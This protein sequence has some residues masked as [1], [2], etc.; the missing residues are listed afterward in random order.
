MKRRASFLTILASATALCTAASAAELR[1]TWWGGNSRHA[2]TQAALQAC[3]EKYDHTV[4]AE[5]TGWKGYLE[6][7]TTQLAGGTEADILQVNWPWLPLFSPKGDGFADLTLFSD[8]IDL[9]Q[10]S[11]AE[12]S[13]TTIDGK[14]NGLPLATTGRVF[15][16]N[17]AVFK[18]ADLQLPKN[19]N[20]LVAAAEAFQDKLG[21]DHYPLEVT[22]DNP[23]LIVM[24]VATQKTGKSLVDA[25]TN[26]VAWSIEELS[27]AIDFYGMLVEKKVTRPWKDWASE[28]YIKLYN[29]PN[30]EAGKIAGSYEWDST[31]F[32]YADPLKDDDALVPVPI[33]KIDGAVTEGVFRKPSM[34]FSISKRSDNQ[35]AAAEIVNC[36]LN[37]KEGIEALGATRGLPA[38]RI[39]LA[40][41]KEAGKIAPELVAANDLVMTGT[42]PEV[43]PLSEHPRIRDAFKDALEMY[44]YGEFSSE[45]AADEI[46]YSINEI[47]EK[48]DP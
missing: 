45:Q 25:K 47:L 39:A 28:G 36:L 2:A 10:W 22:E 33:L 34:V 30:W 21:H 17:Q 37:E 4:K 15:L 38:S 6:K 46:I 19:W 12:L 1:M 41:L 31:Y 43:S 32:K 26:R 23:V 8:I 42:G 29:S 3:G 7:L 5:F 44:A 40:T 11:G 20:E 16:F 35:D 48:F 14:L 9:S 24:L 13:A 27:E 18:K